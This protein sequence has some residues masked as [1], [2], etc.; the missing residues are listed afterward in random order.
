M[1]HL[2]VNA[3]EFR[4]AGQRWLPEISFERTGVPAD[5]QRVLNRRSSGLLRPRHP[6]LTD[7]GPLLRQALAVAQAPT[8]SGDTGHHAPAAAEVV[9]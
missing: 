1:G 7:R 4:S 8:R 2:R 3:A 5:G 9:Q 6:L